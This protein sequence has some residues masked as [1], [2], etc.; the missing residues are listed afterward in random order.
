MKWLILLLVGGNLAAQINSYAINQVIIGPGQLSF[1]L[2]ADSNQDYTF[3]ILQLSPG[4]LAARV[5]PQNGSQILDNSTF[6]Y[7]DT[8]NSGD[9][10]TGFFHSNTGVLGTF[11]SAGQFNGAGQKYLGIRIQA[12]INQL[13]GWVL[14]EVSTARDTL[15]IISCGYN[16]VPSGPINAG[17]TSSSSI[18]NSVSFVPVLNAFPNPVFD[19]VTILHSSDMNFIEIRDLQGRLVLTKPTQGENS[20]ID[21]SSFSPGFYLAGN[22]VYGWVKILLIK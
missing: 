8:L 3:D 16:T 2:N 13:F 6:G 4:V 9:P 21:M 20:I 1:D 19:Q 18:D 5:L 14:L 10:V 12:G 15:K 7:P 11:N 17:Q 22:A